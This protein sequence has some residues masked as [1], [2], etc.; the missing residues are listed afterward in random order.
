M[1]FEVTPLVASAAR[2][3]TGQSA[4]QAVGF[5]DEVGVL[6]NVT[7]VS[8]TPNLVL[9]IEWSVDGTVW[10]PGDPVDA[11]AAITTAVGAA[12]LV[13][14]KAPQMRVKWTITGGTPSLTF[15]VSTYTN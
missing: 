8:G 7:A 4:A 14:V 5:A 10:V 3:T 6:V 9:S 12:K 1:T 11:F 2:T 15:S 13:K